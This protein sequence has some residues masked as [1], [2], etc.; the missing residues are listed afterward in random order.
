MIDRAEQALQ[1]ARELLRFPS[2]ENFGAV[3]RK[4]EFVAGFVRSVKDA[5]ER[6]EPCERRVWEFLIRVPGEMRRIRTLMERP[7]AFYRGLHVLLGAK[8]GS[9]N[10]SGNVNALEPELGSSTRIHL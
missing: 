8:F 9:Y 5:A 1:E 7:L 6:G 10:R 4:L 2:P 3:G